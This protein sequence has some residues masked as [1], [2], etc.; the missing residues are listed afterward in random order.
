MSPEFISY[1]GI[2][3][4]SDKELIDFLSENMDDEVLEVLKNDYNLFV[5]KP[6][7]EK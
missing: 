2:D 4:M 3:K 6:K 7:E 1:Y 5:K